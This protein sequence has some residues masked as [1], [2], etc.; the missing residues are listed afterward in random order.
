[1]LPSGCNPNLPPKTNIILLDLPL[2]YHSQLTHYMAA[3]LIFVILFP[4]N[5]K[6]L[7]SAWNTHPLLS[8]AKR[9]NSK[10]SALSSNIT[11]TERLSWGSLLTGVSVPYSLTHHTVNLFCRTYAYLIFPAYLLFHLYF[12]NKIGKEN[13]SFMHYCILKP[14]I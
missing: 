6:H 4:A 3:T 10:H 14:Q 2:F 13:M 1:M 8:F 12:E 9:V 7:H 11:S 5:P